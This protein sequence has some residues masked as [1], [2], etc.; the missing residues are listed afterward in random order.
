MIIYILDISANKMVKILL[1]VICTLFCLICSMSSTS[2]SRG[3][4]QNKR[5][6]TD[7]EDERLVESLQELHHDKS[8]KADTGFKSG[9]LKQLQIMMERKLPGRGI[10]ASPHI[11]SR[12]KTLKRQSILL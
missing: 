10:L 11:E 9:Y 8:W 4:G 2:C 6:W 3:R 12:I 7:E 1:V 5:Y